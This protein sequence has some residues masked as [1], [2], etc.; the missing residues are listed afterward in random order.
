[1]N[2]N[3]N[4]SGK[5]Y[6]YFNA[7]MVGMRIRKLKTGGGGFLC[8][9]LGNHLFRIYSMTDTTAQNFGK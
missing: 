4:A 3:V 8:S 6:I 7:E 2:T 9:R 1:V 5:C